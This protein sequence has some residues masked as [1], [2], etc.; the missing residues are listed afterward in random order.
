[1]DPLYLYSYLKSCLGQEQ[2]QS[3]V[4]G[5]TIPLIQLKEL[6]RLAI[7]LPPMQSQQKAKALFEQVVALEQ[8]VQRIRGEQECLEQSFPSVLQ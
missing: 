7:P 3:I 2:L 8:S 4:S 6:A 1:M 5:A